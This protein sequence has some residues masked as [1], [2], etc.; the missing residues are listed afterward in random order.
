MSQVERVRRRPT[1]LIQPLLGRFPIA[2][3]MLI[4]F[5]VLLV[6]PT[7][8][9]T[10][11]SY[12][13]LQQEIARQVEIARASS[14]RETM[15]TI[16]ETFD[17]A[18][19][20]SS[21]LSVNQTVRST[22]MLDLDSANDYVKLRGLYD[23]EGA[24]NSFN[25]PF[26][27]APISVLVFDIDGP[28]YRSGDIQQYQDY[29]FLRNSDWFR[30][31]AGSE[32]EQVHVIGLTSD[33]IAG[34][35]DEHRYSLARSIRNHNGTRSVG[36]A[37]V[38]VNASRL[39]ENI[40][41]SRTY[42]ESLAYVR[43]ESHR[44]IAS[45]RSD[46][47][48]RDEATMWG[49]VSAGRSAEQVWD[50]MQ[51]PLNV[52]FADLTFV[53]AVLAD[54]LFIETQ[55]WQTWYLAAIAVLLALYF[56]FFYLV[57]VDIV[58]RIQELVAA[59]AAVSRG[60]L[61]TRVADQHQD[62]LAALSE[63]F[64][65]MVS[66]LNQLLERVRSE[67]EEKR[68]AELKMLQSQIRPHF[69]FNALN[70]IRT[71]ASMSRADNVATMIEALASLMAEAFR[72]ER[73]LIPLSAE[74][75]LVQSYVLLQNLRF[76]NRF[77]LEIDVPQ[78]LEK[79]PVP[80]FILQ[81]LVE[82][83]IRHGYRNATGRCPI[84]VR[85]AMHSGVVE[86]LVIDDGTGIDDQAVQPLP[87]PSDGVGLASVAKRLKLHFGDGAELSASSRSEGGT[88]VRLSIPVPEAVQVES[89]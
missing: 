3:K 43:D 88:M 13:N 16:S 40:P 19:S 17:L 63:G 69:L 78:A 22:L 6:V 53:E 46:Y 67:Q 36:I 14:V 47:V 41:E 15:D 74:I 57:I 42:G 45:T 86:M 48:G 44:V 54:S 37:V 11:F 80:K 26:L 79:L 33:F 18:L 77:S 52:S 25:T 20:Y 50:S 4:V 60:D 70:S 38:S 10:L 61:S 28:V 12:R 8:V 75:E 34:E 68:E 39:F 84:I 73:E 32:K 5:L 7:L 72:H 30:E 31:L 2:G 65:S 56:G 83:C 81:P 85:A 89:R 51:R 55:R 29:S 27:T 71:A 62:E 58:R 21:Y 82:N 87:E 64:N 23:I 76:S 59:T 66:R 49:D 9:V 24:I 35:P 1:G